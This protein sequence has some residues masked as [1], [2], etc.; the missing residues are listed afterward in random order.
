MVSKPYLA[1]ATA[2]RDDAE[3]LREW[4]E[5]HRLVGVER[6]YLYDNGS[7]DGG[8]EVLAPYVEQG[9][10]VVHDWPIPVMGGTGRPIGLIRAFDHCIEQHRDEARWIGFVDVDE[11]LFS[12]EG[13]K[14]S[15]LLGELEE[16]PGVVVH[17]AEFGTSGHRTQPPG[18]VIENYLHRSRHGADSRAY[19]KSIV[20]PSRV[21]RCVSVH[22]FDYRDALAVDENRRPVRT[23]IRPEKT[24]T[25]FRRLRINHYRTKSEAE[26][27]R[28]WELWA[29]TG[30]SQDS[31]PPEWRIRMSALFVEDDAIT[32]YVPALKE[33]LSR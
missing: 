6:F 4:I 1:L 10:A 31:E 5:F 33:A 3:Y 12:P 15:E 28:K 32:S 16:A 18:L 8:R 27:R 17:R 14:L 11:F 19:Y 7:S 2:Y 30:K 29:G 22:H 25:S 24:F 21:A 9:I 13:A 23:G 26:L 20:D